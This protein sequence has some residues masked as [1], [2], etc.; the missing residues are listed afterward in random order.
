MTMKTTINGTELWTVSELAN[1]SMD[2]NEILSIR[3]SQ[4]RE[5]HNRISKLRE[6]NNRLKL[7]N[8]IMRLNIK[9]HSRF[10]VYG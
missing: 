8:E 3:V 5:I 1:G 6:E 7:E 2:D 9:E 10:V 4:V